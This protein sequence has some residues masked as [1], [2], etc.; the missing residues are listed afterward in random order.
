MSDGAP[1]RSCFPRSCSAAS[2]SRCRSCCT[3]CGATSRRKCRSRPC[4]CCSSSPVERSKRRRLRD[5]LLLAARVARCCC[6]P[7]RSRGRTAPAR[8][9]RS[10][11]DRR[12]RSVVQHGGAGRFRSRAAAGRDRRSTNAG[13]ARVAVVAFDERADVMAPPGSAADARRALDRADGRLWRH[14]VRAG[15]RS[16]G[17]SRRR[18]PRATRRRSPTC[19]AR[20]GKTSPRP[21]FRMA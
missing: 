18:R 3:S 12:D 21:S 13:A 1:C 19:S 6:W 7:R 9:R 8:R 17:R 4:T 14:A 16:R 11:R 15:H 10:G 5:L 2:R 20:D